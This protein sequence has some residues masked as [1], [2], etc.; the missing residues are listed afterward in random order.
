MSPGRR[1]AFDPA[2]Y[3]RLLAEV[4]AMMTDLRSCLAP[5]QDISLGPNFELQ[6]E[7]QR[8][9]VSADMVAAGRPLGAS[10]EAQCLRLL[11]RLEE[12]YGGLAKAKVAFQDADELA[13]YSV[14]EPAEPGRLSR[15]RGA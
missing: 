5:G 8:W 12:L 11:N 10:V 13:T 14:K 1:I 2:E 6:P 4:K 7:P 9:N 15:A 3:D